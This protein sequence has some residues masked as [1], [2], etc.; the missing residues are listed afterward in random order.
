[1]HLFRRWANKDLYW[2]ILSVHVLRV[3]FVV[4]DTISNL[5]CHVLEIGWKWPTL[6]VFVLVNR[7]V[8]CKL[9]V[10]LL[11]YLL[12]LCCSWRGML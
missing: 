11:S 4:L 1:M 10:V 7:S 5:R 12:S 8:S 6:G 3:L 2:L 9:R